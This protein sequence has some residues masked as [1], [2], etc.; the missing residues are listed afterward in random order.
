MPKPVPAVFSRFH[1]QWFAA[2]LAGNLLAPAI[3]RVSRERES[4]RAAQRLLDSL[5][6]R[7]REI[8]DLVTEG[9]R[10]EE[11]AARLFISPFTVQTH[12][13]NVLSKLGVRSKAEAVAF[14][15]KHAPR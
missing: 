2:R 5:T 13:S 6:D 3:A 11:I 12:V 10:N 9:L 1:P 14:A 4:G 8:L 7:E 15:L